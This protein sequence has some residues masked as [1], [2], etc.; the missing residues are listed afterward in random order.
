LPDDHV[1][2]PWHAQGH[3]RTGLSRKC[4]AVCTWAARIRHTDIRDVAGVVPGAVMLEILSKVTALQSPPSDPSAE[5][6]GQSSGG[7]SI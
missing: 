2:L 6:G 5:A 3:P 1:L 4:A 7:A